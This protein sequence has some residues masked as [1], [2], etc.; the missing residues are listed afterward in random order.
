M[1]V[2][3]EKIV[4]FLCD[5]LKHYNKHDLAE[6]NYWDDSHSW[7]I[8]YVHLTYHVRVPKILQYLWS[9]LC[10][11]VKFTSHWTWKCLIFVCFCNNV[12]VVF[13]NFNFLN[14]ESNRFSNGRNIRLRRNLTTSQISD[15]IEEEVL[16]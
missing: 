6:K 1:Q 9:Y 7:S 12:V 3:T 15:R 13:L 10:L 5:L 11:H 4:S 16:V 2:I 8:I 14:T